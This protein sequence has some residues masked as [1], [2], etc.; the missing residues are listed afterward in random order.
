MM[1]GA[2]G[3]ATDRLRLDVAGEEEWFGA[4][5]TQ[6]QQA[7]RSNGRAIGDGRWDLLHEALIAQAWDVFHF[8]GS[9]RGR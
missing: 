1:V 7:G 2:S 9:R 3:R 4:A 8:R 5:L 6:L